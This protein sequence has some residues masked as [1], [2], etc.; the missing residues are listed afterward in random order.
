MKHTS[1]QRRV[2]SPATGKKLIFGGGSSKLQGRDGVSTI[3]T[4]SLSKDVE[5]GWYLDPTS[6]GRLCQGTH[7]VDNLTTAAMY[8]FTE[9]RLKLLLPSS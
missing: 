3:S 2:V 5:S 6:D 8:L 1:S 4:L 7:Y 9:L